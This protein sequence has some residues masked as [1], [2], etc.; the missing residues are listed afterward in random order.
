MRTTFPRKKVCIEPGA[1]HFATDATHLD[2][3]IAQRAKT[4]NLIEVR[5]EQYR[6][7]SGRELTDDNVWIHERRREIASLDAIIERLHTDTE[8]LANGASVGGAGA[9]NRLPLLKV[10]TRGSHESVLR[11]ADPNAPG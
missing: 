3:L 6:R 2:E 9:S 7:R 4:V 10:K 11:K 1:V 8:S 5:R